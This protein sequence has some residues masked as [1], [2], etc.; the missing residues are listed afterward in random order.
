ME[1]K[2]W[3]I[4]TFYGKK[5]NRKTEAQ[6]ILHNLFTVCS[7]CKQK[8]VVCQFVDEETNGKMNQTDLPRLWI[9]V[10]LFSVLKKH[11]QSIILKSR[12]LVYISLYSSS[13]ICVAI[14]SYVANYRLLLATFVL[15]ISAT[16]GNHQLSS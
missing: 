16:A 14:F 6:V 4:L 13:L 5:I 10:S 8:F 9:C 7:S 15:D 2:Y 12:N 3:Q 11:K 1:L